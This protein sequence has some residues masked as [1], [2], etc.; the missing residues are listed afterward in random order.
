MRRVYRA[1]IGSLLRGKLFWI[2]LICSLVFIVDY[3]YSQNWEAVIAA[4]HGDWNLHKMIFNFAAMP[5]R[6]AMFMFISIIASVDIMRDKRNG[7][8]DVVRATQLTPGKYLFAKCGA[9][10]TL[11]V[12]AWSVST[13][14]YWAI[15]VFQTAGKLTV[16]YY[17]NVWE[18]VWMSLQRL[19]AISIP[20]LA[21]YLGISV[22]AAVFT[23]KSLFGILA[24]LAYSNL[25]LIPHILMKSESAKT[26]FWDIYNYFGQYV[27]PVAGANV[28][29]WYFRHIKRASE[30]LGWYQEH[31]HTDR[32]L[33]IMLAWAFGIFAVM[34]ILSWLR[35]RRQKD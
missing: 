33:A 11:G 6:N 19:I 17:D 31:P 35:F 8:I 18:V 12:A 24:G 9:Y 5:G 27:Y 3:V 16:Y 4:E 34:F 1:T 23:G 20:A 29:F 7:F 25:T 15:Y 22:F 30:E 10:L 32:D 28:D 26:G 2:C 21:V 13:A 14:G